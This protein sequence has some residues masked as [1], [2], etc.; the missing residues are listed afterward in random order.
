VSDLTQAEE[1]YGQALGFERT[2]RYGA[3]AVF[4]GAGGYHH[5]IGVN[6]WAGEDAPPNPE[7]AV[8]LHLYS[9]EV[10]DDDELR[11]SLARLER[12]GVEF[13]PHRGGY[14]LHDPSTNA[15]LL[16]VAGEIPSS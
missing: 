2:Q 12:A 1:F 7:G 5:H 6:T 8:G 13:Q 11:D 9:I 3:S 15:I 14:L 10:P 16:G 4:F